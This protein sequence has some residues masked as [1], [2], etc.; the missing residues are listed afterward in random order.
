MLHKFGDGN[1]ENVNKFNSSIKNNSN[2]IESEASDSEDNEVATEEAMDVD[3]PGKSLK[4]PTLNNISN[5]A[6]EILV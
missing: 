3:L 5:L 4:K 1:D 2:S 6:K